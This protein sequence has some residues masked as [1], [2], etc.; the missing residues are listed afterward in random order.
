MQNDNETINNNAGSVIFR[1]ISWSQLLL[2]D[3]D[4]RILLSDRDFNTFGLR[5]KLPYCATI[6]KGRTFPV[7]AD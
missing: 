2:P 1:S 7:I 3:S 6:Q 5:V 4:N